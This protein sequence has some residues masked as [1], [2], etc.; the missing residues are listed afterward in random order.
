MIKIEQ[1]KFAYRLINNLLPIN[2]MKLVKTDHKGSDLIKT[3][4][5]QT[6]FKAELNLPLTKSRHYRNSFLHQSTKVFS[7][8]PTKVKNKI[9]LESFKRSIKNHI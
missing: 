6:R 3:H 8:L 5:Y 2:L 1:L 9:T 4:H 7:T